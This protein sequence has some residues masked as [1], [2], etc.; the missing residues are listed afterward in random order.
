MSTITTVEQ[1]REL[2]EDTV[3]RERG[4]SVLQKDGDG[5]EKTYGSFVDHEGVQLPAQTL[6]PPDDQRGGCGA[7][8]PRNL[9]LVSRRDYETGLD[10]VTK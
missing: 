1:L 5:W 10:E 2:P 6:H 3:I 8:R 9:F 4:G 7:P